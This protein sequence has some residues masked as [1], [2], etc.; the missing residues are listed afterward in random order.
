MAC[1]IETRVQHTNGGTSNHL[2]LHQQC[3]T[4]QL[5]ISPPPNNNFTIIKP[6]TTPRCNVGNK[7]AA[8]KSN[9]AA[10]STQSMREVIGKS[11]FQQNRIPPWRDIRFW[12]K[13]EITCIQPRQQHVV[14]LTAEQLQ[15]Q[16]VQDRHLPDRP[17]GVVFRRWWCGRFRALSGLLLDPE[18]K[19]RPF[20][21]CCC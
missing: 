19:T 15:L 4:R 13:L 16:R 12:A 18:R 9:H 17:S 14:V 7:K 11:L 1:L 6:P 3:T 10:E 20:A 8:T 2:L 21:C 5:S